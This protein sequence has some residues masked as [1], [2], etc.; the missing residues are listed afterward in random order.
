M[1]VGYRSF[2]MFWCAGCQQR[3]EFISEDDKCTDANAARCCDP[4]C[5]YSFGTFNDEK[6]LS[7]DGERFTTTN[8]PVLSPEL[9]EKA[10]RQRLADYRRTMLN[11]GV[12]LERLRSA[13][14]RTPDA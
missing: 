6:T 1:G 3:R 7:E 4:D 10:K 14:G 12:R 11:S 5:G 13:K 2:G 9:V 8:H